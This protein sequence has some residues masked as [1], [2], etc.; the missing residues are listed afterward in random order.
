MTEDHHFP[1]HIGLEVDV[2]LLVGRVAPRLRKVRH[3][4]IT[5]VGGEED[6]EL[7]DKVALAAPGVVRQGEAAQVGEAAVK[8]G[9]TDGRIYLLQTCTG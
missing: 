4:E 5:F 9:G 7:A 3:H 2:G 1:C 6:D 8:G